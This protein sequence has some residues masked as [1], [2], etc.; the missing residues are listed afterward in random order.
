MSVLQTR[1]KLRRMEQK[2]GEEG[3]EKN[4]QQNNNGKDV[5]FLFKKRAWRYAQ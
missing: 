1:G 5:S 2:K 3:A 4:E